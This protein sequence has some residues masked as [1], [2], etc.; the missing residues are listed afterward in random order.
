[1]DQLQRI[2]E[3]EVRKLARRVLR[4]PECAALDCP[5]GTRQLPFHCRGMASSGIE[6]T[7]RRIERLETQLREARAD[8]RREIRRAHEEEKV[9][10]SELARR[11][12]LSRT[13]V[14]QLLGLDDG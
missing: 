14:R 5:F 7:L 10:I 12:K 8:L 4:E 11:L 1:M 3:R 13:R 9:S 6:K 2:F